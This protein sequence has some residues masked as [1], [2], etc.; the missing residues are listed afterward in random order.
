MREVRA[1]ENPAALTERER[2]VL[3]PLAQG[4]TTRQIAVELAVGESTVRTHVRSILAKL[5][6]QLRTPA[7]RYAAQT[8][9]AKLD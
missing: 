7:V 6:V 1:R 8:G 3:H 4:K 5:G 2:D 9:L